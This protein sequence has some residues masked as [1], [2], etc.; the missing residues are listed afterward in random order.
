M[1]KPAHDVLNYRPKDRKVRLIGVPLVSAAMHFVFHDWRGFD[2]LFWGE[3]FVDFLITIVIWEGIRQIWCLLQNRFSNYTQTKKRIFYSI[4]AVLGYTL[5]VIAGLKLMM[6]VFLG[7]TFTKLSFGKGYLASLVPTFMIM[8]IYE[9]SFFFWAWRSNVQKTEA[10]ARENVQSQ[11]ETLKS[12]LNPHFL[13][14]SLNTL[15]SLIDEENAPAQKYLEQL[16]DVYRYVL[17]SRE[18]NTVLLE[19]EMA[20]LDAYIYL[21]KIR[22][23][24]NLQIETQIS[25]TAYQCHI[26]PLSLQMLVENAIKHNVVSRENPLKIKILQQNDYLIIENNWQEKKTFEKS[27]KVG[28]ENIINRYRL[29]TNRDVEVLRNDSSFAV[30][31]PLL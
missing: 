18:K 21:N 7:G 12:Q 27:T 26:A 20:F 13:F 3:L 11:L 1:P 6:Y 17:V 30:K 9:S 16:S 19:D 28:L 10:L 29:L 22:F 4:L 24:E 31:I 25:A 23:R 14:N 5:V 2:R 15:A 8:S